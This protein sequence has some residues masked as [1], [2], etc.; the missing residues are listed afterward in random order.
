MKKDYKIFFH[1]LD[2]LLYTLRSRDTESNIYRKYE[3]IND[4]IKIITNQI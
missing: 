1:K 4:K 3:N 2:E